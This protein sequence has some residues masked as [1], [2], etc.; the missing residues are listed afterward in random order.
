MYEARIARFLSEDPMKSDPN[1][2]RYASN[3]PVMASD[4]SGMWTWEISK[5]G[6]L[7]AISQKGDTIEGLVGL[8]YPKEK[9]KVPTS[10]DDDSQLDAGIKINL[11]EWLNK[12]T[13]KMLRQQQAKKITPKMKRSC[14]ER[15]EATIED[16]REDL[17][18]GTVPPSPEFNRRVIKSYE[19]LEAATPGQ[20]T[21]GDLGNF[22]LHTDM[23][24]GDRKSGSGDCCMF[25]LIC[26]GF[27]EPKPG[28]EFGFDLT[29]HGRGAKWLQ[30]SPKIDRENVRVG[31]VLVWPGERPDFPEHTA[32]IVG[33]DNNGELYLLE[34]AG[35]GA[36]LQV[37]PLSVPHIGDERKT[38][39]MIIVRPE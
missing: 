28:E 13:A 21:I 9:M 4:P 14:L 15:W 32:M 18:T 22:Y 34:R 19:D 10:I 30:D 37:D 26:T 27:Y 29:V 24:T 35:P 20:A 36:L 1:E 12:A 7:V 6:E 38:D 2:Y 23:W 31:D 5:T 39:G 16:A 11:T 3:T 17:A 8:G 33:I 25:T